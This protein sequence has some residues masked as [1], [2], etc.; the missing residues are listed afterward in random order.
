MDDGEIAAVIVIVLVTLVLIQVFRKS[1]FVVR[2]AEVRRGV[3]AE[4]C[5]PRSSLAHSPMQRR[6]RCFFGV[7]DVSCCLHWLCACPKP[8]DSQD[9]WP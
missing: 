9:W 3:F 8:C 4:S 6:K 1:C 2:N 5:S 7:P